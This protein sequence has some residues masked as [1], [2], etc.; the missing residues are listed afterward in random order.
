MKEILFVCSGN[1][2]RSQMA[3]G[4]YNHLTQTHNAISA[5]VDPKTPTKYPRLPDY[6]CGIMA[7]EGIDVSHQQV[8]LIR[9]HMVREA[10]EI[11]V[12]CSQESCPD[13]LVQSDKVTYWQ[14]EDPFEANNDNLRKIRNQIKEKIQFMLGTLGNNI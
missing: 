1:V 14:I 3:E 12:M 10:G 8:K 13:Y 11:F 9:E 4:Y 7:E 2:G 6:I 5:G